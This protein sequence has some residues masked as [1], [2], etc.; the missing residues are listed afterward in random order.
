MS[1][2]MSSEMSSDLK[3][4]GFRFLITG[5]INTGVT[6][7]IY[8]LL[9]LLMLDYRMAYL[10]SFVSGI[11]IALVLNSQFVFNTPLTFKKAAGFVAAYG[12]QLIAGILT[13]QLLVEYTSVSL[14][15]APLCV[16]IFTVPLS[17][18]MSRYALRRL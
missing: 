14:V 1:S 3:A 13:L 4:T 8:L 5:I 15:I 17:F 18:L 9:L 16:M 12:L 6:Y 2:E 10:L 11:A 7:A